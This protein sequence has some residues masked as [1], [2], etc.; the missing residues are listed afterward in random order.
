MCGIVGAAC[1]LPYR[2]SVSPARLAHMRDLLT[3][4]G[5]DDAGIWSTPNVALAHRRLS[6]LDPT[7]AGHQPM[8]TPDARH[9]LVYNGE[10]YNDTELRH[11]LARQ[12]VTFASNCDTET[13]LAVL[14][15]FGSDAA[16]HLRGMYAFAYLDLAAQRL[17]LARDPLG[18]KPLYYWIGPAGDHLELVF[19]S[20]PRAILAHPHVP[21]RPD[22]HAI[23]HYLTTIRTT[24]TD[25]TLF[26][27]VRTVRPGQWLTFDLRDPTLDPDICDNSLITRAPDATTREIVERSIVAHLRTDVPLCSLL[28]GGLDSTIIAAVSAQHHSGLH[29]YCAGSPEPASDT[30][31]LA[32]ARRA[33]QALGLAHTQT[34][35][36]HHAFSELWPSLITRLG[37][38]LSTPN[39]VAINAVAR[40]LKSASHTVA[41]SGEGADELFAGYDHSLALARDFHARNPHASLSD[42]A[43]FEIEA[44]AWIPTSLKPA[45]LTDRFTLDTDRDELLACELEREFRWCER[46]AAAAAS[47]TSQDRRLHHHLLF[48]QRVNLAG[49]L[50]RLD[51]STMLESVEGRTPLADAVVAAHARSLSMDALINWRTDRVETHVETKIPLRRAFADMIPAEPLARPKASFPLPFQEWMHTLAPRVRSSTLVRDIF[52]TAAIEIVAQNPGSAWRIAWPMI[53]L[54]LWDAAIFGS[55]GGIDTNNNARAE[56]RAL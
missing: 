39:E 27:G 30:D 22:L 49:L 6:I 29:T 12:G 51:T 28:S 46:A 7:P 55:R 21:A 23:N 20:E 31:D 54:A 11:R 19:A 38:P 36:D 42:M 56:A 25:H 10:L 32:C 40:D 24:L 13:L 35:I 4:R 41:L 48:Q 8:L 43:R 17:T 33:A 52:S 53:N 1:A 2:L 50:Q 45:A 26:E 5:P 14:A 34:I 44:N 15:R 9:A 47:G 18:I 37:V 3:H 16:E